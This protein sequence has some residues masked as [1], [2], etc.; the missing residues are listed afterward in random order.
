MNGVK[1]ILQCRH[2]KGRLSIKCRLLSRKL[3]YTCGASGANWL[4][5]NRVSKDSFHSF[6]KAYLSRCCMEGVMASKNGH[7]TVHFVAENVA[8][9]ASM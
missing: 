9:M 1:Q 2:C 6:P 7:T 5:E 4:F 3:L 8:L